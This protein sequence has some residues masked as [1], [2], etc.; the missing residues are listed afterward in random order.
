MDP[1]CQ[2]HQNKIEEISTDVKVIRTMLTGNGDI[3]I[4][5]QVRNHDSFIKKFKKRRYD[6]TTFAFR[7][8]LT[9][10]IGFIA[11]KVGLK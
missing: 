7:I 5:E 8:V 10:V 4:C 1:Q 11:V 2:E 6:L 3:G 9:I